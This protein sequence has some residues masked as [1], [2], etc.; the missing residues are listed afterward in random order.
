MQFLGKMV[1]LRHFFKLLDYFCILLPKQKIYFCEHLINST[2]LYSLHK[3]YIIKNGSNIVKSVSSV[4]YWLNLVASMWRN[5][6]RR[7]YFLLF[8]EIW[9]QFIDATEIID[10]FFYR[11]THTNTYNQIIWFWILTRQN[12][13]KMSQ[14]Q[15]PFLTRR[16]CKRIVDIAALLAEHKFNLCLSPSSRFNHEDTRPP[17][18]RRGLSREYILRIPSVS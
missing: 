16:L 6:I 5:N 9:N 13:K 1:H 18:G 12:S 2:I 14:T 3:K 10:D 7:A 11:K 4:K 15:M 17:W 8:L